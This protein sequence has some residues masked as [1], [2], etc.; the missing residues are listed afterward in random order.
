MEDTTTN[1]ADFGTREDGI[2]ALPHLGPPDHEKHHAHEEGAGEVDALRAQLESMKA[3]LAARE[4]ELA[5]EKEKSKRLVHKK[6]VKKKVHDLVDVDP[7][8]DLAGKF[9]RCVTLAEFLAKGLGLLHLDPGPSGK[10]GMP[11]TGALF[12]E[13][14]IRAAAARHGAF[15]DAFFAAASEPAE[16]KIAARFNKARHWLARG[17]K[18][19][20][21]RRA[22]V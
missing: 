13:R 18:S 7:E 11:I 19:S 12:L 9:E 14:Q 1:G 16:L 21:Q 2:T 22:S 10:K 8:D 15:T 17:V 4:G 20:P 5:D 6:H 3:Q